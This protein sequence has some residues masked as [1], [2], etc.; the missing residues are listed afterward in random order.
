MSTSTENVPGYEYDYYEFEH[1]P[2]MGR[3]NIFVFWYSFPQTYT[4][5]A[6]SEMLTTTSVV[7]MLGTTHCTLAELK[8]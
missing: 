8:G 6:K 3:N 1:T 7:P 5:N 2:T 4:Y